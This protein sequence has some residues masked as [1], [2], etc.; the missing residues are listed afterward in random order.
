MY[1]VGVSSGGGGI[2]GVYGVCKCGVCKYGVYICVAHTQ[3]TRKQIHAHIHALSLSLT[4]TH[5]PT[6]KQALGIVGPT[7]NYSTLG[8]RGLLKLVGMVN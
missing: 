1:R 6:N 7:C 2:G 3:I 8:G 5:K 4:H